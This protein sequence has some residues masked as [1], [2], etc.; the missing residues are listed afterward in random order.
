MPMPVLERDEFRTAYAS[1]R[2]YTRAAPLREQL[3]IAV[4]TVG[5][6]ILRGEPLT[7]QRG[8]AIGTAEALAMPWLVLVCHSASG[9]HLLAFCAPSRV[10]F[11]VARGA[12]DL[13][14]FRDKRPC[15]YRCFAQL[16]A[17]TLVMPLL[18]LVLHFLH[19]RTEYLVA[20]IA[21]GG[22]SLVV[23]V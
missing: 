5:L 12:V 13:L 16:T 8:I 4:S 17:E 6:L 2:L 22:E 9:Y 7:G 10:L 23:A 11:L 15:S 19:A 21:P 18:A 14:V 20:A 1:D 3:S